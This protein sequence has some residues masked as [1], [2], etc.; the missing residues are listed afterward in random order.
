MVR[1]I[2]DAG[3]IGLMA[4][5]TIFSWMIWWKVF[6]NAAEKMPEPPW[7]DT[8]WVYYGVELGL[9]ILIALLGIRKE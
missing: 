8:D 7:W 6:V 3:P 2:F 1:K 9:L 5:M 4:T